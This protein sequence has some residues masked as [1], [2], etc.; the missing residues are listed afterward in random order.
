MTANSRSPVNGAVAIGFHSTSEN[1]RDP[2]VGALIYIN[3]PKKGD[4]CRTENEGDRLS[5]RRRIGAIR[6]DFNN[7]V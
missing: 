4:E 2:N 3:F 7:G 5:P 6:R 1:I